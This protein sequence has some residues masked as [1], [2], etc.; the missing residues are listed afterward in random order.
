MPPLLQHAFSLGL[1]QSCCVGHSIALWPVD[2]WTQ[3]RHGMAGTAPQNMFDGVPSPY[4]D[5]RNRRVPGGDCGS[6]KEGIHDVVIAPLVPS[7]VLRRQ[8]NER[9]KRWVSFRAPKRRV[10][11]VLPFSSD[12]RSCAEQPDT[13][14]CLVLLLRAL[15]EGPH[16]PG[17]HTHTCTR[18]QRERHFLRQPYA[19]ASERHP[20]RHVLVMSSSSVITVTI[21]QE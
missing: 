13:E 14:S 21:A 4:L 19:P 8:A 20:P 12:H 15:L 11:A 1:D 2:A 16:L 17:L 3:Q 5:R 9:N 10:F 6:R 18:D 7:F